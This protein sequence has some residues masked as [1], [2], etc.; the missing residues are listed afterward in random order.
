MSVPRSMSL[1]L[2]TEPGR[3]DLD[4]VDAE[5]DSLDL[6]L[7]WLW[8]LVMD[9]RVLACCSSGDHKELNMTE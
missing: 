9:G 5:F 8:E 3:K 7:V 4:E 1:A 2:Y 6:S